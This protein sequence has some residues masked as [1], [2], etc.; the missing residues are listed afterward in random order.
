M[1]TGICCGNI[2]RQLNK[3]RGIEVVIT[4]RSWK[5]F[6]REGAWVRIPPS[7]LREKHIYLKDGCA[8]CILKMIIECKLLCTLL[9]K[10]NDIN[11]I[12]NR[13]KIAKQIERCRIIK[14]WKKILDKIAE[15]VYIIFRT[16]WRNTQEAEGAPLERE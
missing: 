5:P 3:C 7:A 14:K 16:F 4:R 10:C 8:F 2:S 6:V 11:R 12:V 9:E 13:Q 1:T 15:F